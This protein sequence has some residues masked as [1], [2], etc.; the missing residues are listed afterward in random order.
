[1]LILS[2]ALTEPFFASPAVSLTNA[3]AALF[4]AAAFSPS[5]GL[6]AGASKSTIS[7][8][9]YLL[10]SYALVLV[11]LAFGAIMTK[12]G[13]GRAGRL[14]PALSRCSALL[15]NARVVFSV[16]I[17]GSIYAVY[18]RNPATFLTLI[19]AWIV[20]VL[21]RPVEAV[22]AREWNWLRTPPEARGSVT[23]LR[24]PSLVEVVVRPGAAVEAGEEFLLGHDRLPAVVIDTGPARVG[25]WA[26]LSHD[27]TS[28]PKL[29]DP[30]FACEEALDSEANLASMG[31]VEPG[32]DITELRF[33]VPGQTPQLREGNLVSVELR[34]QRVLYQV[35]TAHART[36]SLAP[37]IDHRFIEAVASKIGAWDEAAREFKSVAWLP[38]PGSRVSLEVS[39]G[40]AFQ[41]DAIGALPDSP[42]AIRVNPDTLVSHNTAILGILGIGKTYLAFE[43]IRRVLAA[44]IKV[45]VLDITGQYA[46]HFRSLV[47]D[48]YETSSNQTIACSIKATRDTSRQNVH[49]GGNVREFTTAVNQDL[50]AFLESDYRLKIYNPGAFDVTRQDSKPFQGVAS[51]APLTLVE[52]TRVFAE[53]LL[54][55][56]SDQIS[57]RARVCLVLEEA[58]SLIPEWNSTTYEGDQR[59]SNGTAKAVLQGR[60]Y[61][62]GLLLITQRTANVTKTVLNQCNTV[63]ALR[64]YDATGMEFLKNY[65]GESYAG[66]LSS[67]AERSAVVFGRGSSCPAPVVIRLNDH[68]DMVSGFWVDQE[69]SIP[70]PNGTPKPKLS[71]SS[72]C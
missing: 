46:S 62:L 52:T 50:K 67:L 45:V 61:G 8:G 69:S 70:V 31:P 17:L 71:H 22:F 12:D 40:R 55:L 15:G 25:S 11:V 39:N 68:E 72:G 47:P 24:H 38:T 5:A 49:E 2:A 16:V 29:G 13:T 23:G 7:A 3:V 48:I 26:L 59:A 56:L 54:M 43:L 44:D 9:K 65:I 64:T 34:S 42:Y 14:S 58:H 36:E 19:I 28:Q 18:S 35:V 51:I 6:V 57:D 21:I 27:A 53:Q 30:I 33:R 32:T 60:K 41:S 10:L 1:M 63:F 37:D 4:V 66:V 20:I